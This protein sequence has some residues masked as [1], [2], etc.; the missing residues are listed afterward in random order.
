MDFNYN[1]YDDWVD[2]KYGIY[3]GYI[4]YDRKRKI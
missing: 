4:P 2:Q 1:D 3:E